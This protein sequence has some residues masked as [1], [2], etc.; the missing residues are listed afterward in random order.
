MKSIDF[1]NENQTAQMGERFATRGLSL[2]LLCMVLVAH[3]ASEAA[4]AA[5]GGAYQATLMGAGQG[6]EV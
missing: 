4:S 5:A 2:D 1:T 6:V 3:H